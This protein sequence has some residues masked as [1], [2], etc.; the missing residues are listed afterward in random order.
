MN[1]LHPNLPGVFNSSQLTND[2]NGALWTI[3]VEVMFYL[4]IPI[5]I[6]FLS[7]KT[8]KI[9]YFLIIYLLSVAYKNLLELNS[10][11][12]ANY[13]M[14]ARQLPGFMSYFISGIYLNYYKKTFINLKTKLV[15]VA[16]VVFVIEY[17]FNL[18]ILTPLALATIIFYIAFSFPILNNFGKKNDISYGIYL[19]HCPIIKTITYL[20]YFNIYN[21]FIVSF[22]TISLIISVAFLSW[23]YIEKPIL[24]SIKVKKIDSMG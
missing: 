6:N 5:I 8:R 3:K 2:I 10:L 13:I 14:F 12:N 18:E 11:N 16:I 19:Y 22:C 24:K 9:R 20:G 7:N 21:P 17:Y 23:K 4:T 1:F 15:V